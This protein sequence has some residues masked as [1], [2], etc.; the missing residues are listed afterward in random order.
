MSMIICEKVNKQYD[1]HH[2][3]IDL[4][5]II[6]KGEVFGLLGPNGAGKTTSISMMTS[7]IVPSNGTIK[8]NDLDV[9]ESGKE[10]KKIVGI[11]PQDIALYPMLNAFDNL[12]FFGELYGIKGKMLKERVEELLHLVGLADRA[13]EPIK[14]YSGGMKR[15]INIAAALLHQPLVVFMDEPTVGIDPQSRNQI[16]ELIKLL[17]S[18]GI[19]IIYTTHYMEEA[20]ALCDR[21]AIVDNGKMIA[22]GTVN[23][24]VS[25][26]YGGV[27][28][29]SGEDEEEVVQV[30]DL[31]QKKSFVK[32]IRL[33]ENKLDIL[34]EDINKNVAEL[35]EILN[36]NDSQIKVINMMHPSLE[37]LFLYKTG[38]KL[39]D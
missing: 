7:Q 15:R 1:N 5:L 12:K 14:N 31:F 39:R 27:V 34:V 13:K 18:Q 6:N 23:E 36:E 2:V 26:V 16:Y 24:L 17:K 21:V 4:D 33:A 11:V 3:V 8:I 29:L 22:L 38:K 28:E 37:T 32:N 35:L 19:T 9:K 25:Q 20:T 30:R 10:V